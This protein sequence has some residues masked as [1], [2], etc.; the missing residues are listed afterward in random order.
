MLIL[1][2]SVNL[3]WL[4]TSGRGSIWHLVLPAITLGSVLMALITRLVRSGM[5]DV[6]GEDYIRTA[7]A[8]GLQERR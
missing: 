2:F 1:V 8:K 5:L 7:R 6:L 3:G 4:P